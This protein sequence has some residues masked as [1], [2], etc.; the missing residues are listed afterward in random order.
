MGTPVVKAMRKKYKNARI[1]LLLFAFNSK[2]VLDKS[3][4]DNTYIWKDR[5]FTLT[6]KKPNILYSF[7]SRAFLLLK[8]KTEGYD[9]SISLDP[10]ASEHQ[11]KIA[12]LIGAKKRIGFE[13]NFYTGSVKMNN[14]I[15]SIENNLNL[16]K[17]L[18]IIAKDKKPIFCISKE[19]KE[20]ADNFFE[21][22]NIKYAI[23]IHAGVYFKRPMRKWSI[24]KW[25]GLC[26]EII[27]KYGCNILSIE[28]ASE[29]GVTDEIKKRI[30]DN[31]VRDKIQ[32]VRTTLKNVGAII[33]KC[34]LFISND[35]G[36]MHTA[37]CFIRT[38]GIFGYTDYIKHPPSNNGIVVRKDLNC[39]KTCTFKNTAGDKMP[40][41][42]LKCLR[43]IMVEDILKEV[44]KL[45]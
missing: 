19:N 17:P 24:D 27:K 33:S 10:S 5:N 31:Y 43:L 30:E 23:G 36:I 45:W 26:K 7:F 32:T 9:L 41:C 38:I 40:E 22:N 42:N 6:E 37:S 15:T 11:G 16:L 34:R 8:L 4:V 44:E 20:Y 35:S 25:A 29:F 21:D 3:Y 13:N 28:G 1:D 39:Y 18:G 14:E 12:K 2:D